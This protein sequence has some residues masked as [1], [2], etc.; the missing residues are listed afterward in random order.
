MALCTVVVSLIALN[1][2]QLPEHKLD[3]Y[4]SR[5][6]ADE[7]MP[8]DKT[9][10]V[11]QKMIRQ[12]YIIKV[13]DRIGDEETVEWMVGPRGRTE[14]GNRGVQ[15]LVKEVY[16]EGAPEDLDKRL[17][18]SL[19]MEM[20]SIDRIAGEDNEESMANEST[21]TASRPRR[22]RGEDNDDDY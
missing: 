13:K 9:Q 14:I 17:Q 3:R 18:R 15:G 11:L 19:G 21:T 22:T 16:G 6:N 4:L 20:S 8:M 5:M 2:G 10:V 12:G 7:N 1:G